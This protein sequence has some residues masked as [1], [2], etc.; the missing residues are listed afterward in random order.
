M[1]GDFGVNEFRFRLHSEPVLEAKYKAFPYQEEATEFVACRDYSAIFHEQ[2]LGKTKIA[3][4]VILR[5]L[6]NKEVDT[7]LVFTKKGLIA[8]WIREFRSHSQLP[9]PLGA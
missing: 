8:N 4:D 6:Q 7:V 2:G 9:S 3:I 5:W 1:L